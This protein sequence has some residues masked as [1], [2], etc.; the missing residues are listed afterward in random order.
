MSMIPFQKMIFAV[1]A[2]HLLASACSAND[3]S[4]R[5]TLV[6]VWRVGDDGLTTKLAD[7]IEEGI[8]RSPAF[9]LS[10][11]RK[12]NTLIVAI[13]TNVGWK[14]VGNRT[15]V[16]YTVNFSLVSAQSLGTSSGACWADSLAKCAARVVKDAKVA[17][18]KI[19]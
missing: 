12:P 14:Q 10:T 5:P 16:L 13:P 1:I 15:R 11:G 19:P 2:L 8:R 9:V 18:G 3:G 6:E 7:A 4:R 17:A